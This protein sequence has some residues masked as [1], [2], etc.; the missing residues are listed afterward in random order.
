MS[1]PIKLYLH[2]DWN[3]KAIEI[4]RILLDSDSHAGY[5]ALVEKIGQLFPALRTDKLT[6]A[7][8]DDEEDIVTISSDQE[9]SDALEM[10][11]G[12]VF[13]LLIKEQE[14]ELAAVQP[15]HSGSLQCQEGIGL[16]ENKHAVKIKTYQ[17]G[18]N[19]DAT[20]LSH[21]PTPSSHDPTPSSH[22]PTPSSH[23]P[24]S[25]SHD[26]IPSSHD[27]AAS[28]HDTI[29]LSHDTT[30]S[31]HDPTTSSHDPTASSH[32]ATPSSHDPSPPELTMGTKRPMT[33]PNPSSQDLAK[34]PKV[35]QCHMSVTGRSHSSSPTTHLTGLHLPSFHNEPHSILYDESISQEEREAFWLLKDMGYDIEDGCIAQLVCE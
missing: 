10:Y 3:E 13:R 35:S 4:R 25:S 9:L 24:T 6:I 32:D 12:S 14:N 27:P 11:N 34:R 7:W 2:R 23:D 18:W 1:V 30:S 16:F 21:D 29:P 8:L 26:P 22:D 15:T 5:E 20:S 19:N 31:S 17:Q 33:Y 28:S